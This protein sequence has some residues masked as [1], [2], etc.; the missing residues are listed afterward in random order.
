MGIEIVLFVISFLS[1]SF[2]ES[3]ANIS[4]V[5]YLALLSIYVGTKEF[6]RWHN[7]HK[8]IHYGELSIIFWTILVIWLMVLNIIHKGRFHFPNELVALYIA[9]LGI[10]AITQESKALYKTCLKK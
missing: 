10:F 6:N 4:G 2:Y 5:I 7:Y 3:L 9:V 8:S 1:G